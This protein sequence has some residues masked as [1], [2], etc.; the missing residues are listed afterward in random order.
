MEKKSFYTIKEAAEIKG[1][2]EEDI[3][4]GMREGRIKTKQIGMILKIPESELE[5]IR[6]PLSAE[7]IEQYMEQL[8]P[9]LVSMI[10]TAP[11]YGSCGIIIT[12]H[13]GKIVKVCVQ[14]EKTKREV[15]HDKS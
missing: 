5:N 15:K 13:D 3:L 8:H 6:I 4:L 11:D 14:Y 1:I 9:D 7:K 10:Q 2:S 12:L